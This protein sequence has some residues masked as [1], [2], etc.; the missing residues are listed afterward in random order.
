MDFKHT[1]LSLC[2]PITSYFK[3]RKLISALLRNRRFFIKQ[4]KLAHKEYL[5]IGCG[6]YPHKDFINLDY[7][8]QPG[9]DICW[10]VTKGIPF[11]DESLMGIYS[12]HCFEHLPLEAVDFVLGEC[13]RILKPGGCIRIVV[14]DGQ[15]YLTGYSEIIHSRT[16]YQL[17]YASE[18]EYQGLYTP[19]M[20]VNR[21]FRGHGH[22]F[23]YDFDVLRLLLEKNHFGKICKESYGSGRNPLMLIDS[24][25]R[26]V[27]SL[28]VEASK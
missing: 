3:V 19:I 23:I 17:P 1:K 14:P 13:W 2:R 11:A 28:Y 9:I 25:A 26:R 10:D 12:E 5:D 7:G 15:L 6:P 21:I 18:D 22:A 20:S 27:E 8:W 24:E 4:D 16:D